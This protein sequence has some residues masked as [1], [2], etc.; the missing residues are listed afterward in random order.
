MQKDKLKVLLVDD[1]FVNL[2]LMITYLNRMN[3]IVDTA[4]NGRQA[5]ELLKLHDYDIVFMDC[6]MPE[7][8]GYEAT[9]R[10]R[11][12]DSEKSDSLIVA[13]TANNQHG[14]REHCLRSGMNDFV[15]KPVSN[16]DIQDILGKYF[17]QEL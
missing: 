5:I 15:A 17:Y 16:N 12:L 13:V 7:M 8:D 9:E 1:N 14:H 6:K 4:K 2:R 3:C 10:I 11:A